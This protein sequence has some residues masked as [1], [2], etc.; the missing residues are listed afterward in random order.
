MVICLRQKY[1]HMPEIKGSKLI[2]LM[3]YS[4][5]RFMCVQVGGWGNYCEHHTSITCIC[6]SDIVKLV[7]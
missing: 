2:S 6:N 4:E 1:G 3:I 7:K 5:I